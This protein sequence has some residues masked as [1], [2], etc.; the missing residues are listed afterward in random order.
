MSLDIKGFVETSLVDWDGKI[1]SVVFLPGCNFRCPYCQNVGLIA[2]PE[3]Y[4]SIPEEKVFEYLESHR[5]F[6]DGVC[7]TGGE[8]TLHKAAGLTQFIKRLKKEGFLVK[9]DTNGSDLTYI[10]ELTSSDLI[11]FIA[12]DIK[13]PLEAYNKATN[14]KVD[15]NA[16]KQTADFLINGNIDYEFRTTAVP[17]IVGISDVEGMAKLIAGAKKYVLQQF[18]PEHCEDIELKKLRPY[19]TETTAKMMEVARKYVK[20]VVYR[21]K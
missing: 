2:R 20:N 8:P 5:N 1:A 3:K 14:V 9:L 12:M 6:I 4:K 18:E 16:L 10:K 21:G 13:A 15:I 17:T 7:I 19:D 11:D